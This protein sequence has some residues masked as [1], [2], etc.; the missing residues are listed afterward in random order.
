[1]K[2][3]YTIVLAFAVAVSAYSA[4]FS[5]SAGGGMS[6]IFHWKDAAV[7]DK[8]KNYVNGNAVGAD[9][10]EA[11]LRGFNDTKE[12]VNGF[13]LHGFLDGTYAEFNAAM[14]FVWVTQT[15]DNPV[16]EANTHDPYMLTQ[17]YFSLYGKYPVDIG[18]TRWTV[19]PL[20]GITYQVALADQG[21]KFGDD[22]SNMTDA[23]NPSHQISPTVDELWNSFWLKAGVGADYHFLEKLFLRAELLYGLK[24]P[25]GFEFANAK[26]WA[27]NLSGLSNGVNLSVAIGY[28]VK[29]FNF[30]GK[31]KEKQSPEEI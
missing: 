25:N 31:S 3:A 6:G 18:T 14:L 16:M 10:T 8:Y 4:D 13:G 11:M 24:L 15:L 22:L 1:M 28:K 9:T 21:G 23:A 29:S 12:R 19:F 17:L 7:K 26:Y 27:E 30:G 20:V 2:Y 5:L